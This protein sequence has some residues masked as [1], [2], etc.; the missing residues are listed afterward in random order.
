MD[1]TGGGESCK[2]AIVVFGQ[3][4]SF[5]RKYISI[6]VCYAGDHPESMLM[7]QWESN[8]HVRNAGGIELCLTIHLGERTV[9]VVGMCRNE[10]P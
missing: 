6:V 8:S 5:Y 4:R 7:G 1:I 3:L 10:L 9:T 2:H